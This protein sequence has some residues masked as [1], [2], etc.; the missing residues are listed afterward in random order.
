MKRF[1]NKTKQT[2]QP[3]VTQTERL[4]TQ[5]CKE[6]KEFITHGQFPGKTGVGHLSDFFFSALFLPLR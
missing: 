4:S 1:P 3:L 6:R 2:D 5:R